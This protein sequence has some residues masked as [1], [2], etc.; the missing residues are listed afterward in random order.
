MFVNLRSRRLSS[1]RLSS[2][3]LSSRRLSSR[4]VWQYPGNAIFCG[5]NQQAVVR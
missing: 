3:R 2:R 4:L 5:G 1:R